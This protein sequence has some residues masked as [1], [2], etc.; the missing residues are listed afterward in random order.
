MSYTQLS[1]EWDRENWRHAQGIR[2]TRGETNGGLA[3]R[4]YSIDCYTQHCIGVVK[5]Y[6]IWGC[7]IHHQPSLICD[8]EKAIKVLKSLILGVDEK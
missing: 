3:D 4:E 7:S 6:F 2:S 8:K 5:G 1:G